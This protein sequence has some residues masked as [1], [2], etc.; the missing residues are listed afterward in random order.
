M[1]EPTGLSLLQ[2]HGGYVGRR[3]RWS[4]IRATRCSARRR[5]NT[6]NNMMKLSNHLQE[7]GDDFE[8]RHTYMGMSSKVTLSAIEGG[9]PHRC[10]RVPVF[11]TLYVDTRL[12]PGQSPILVRRELEEASCARLQPSHPD[13]AEPPSRHEHLHESMGFAVR[14]R[15]N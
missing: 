11:C 4:A 3:S 10:S 15:R 14:A 7:W 13:F 6:I 9:W 12:M 1:G 8:R 5:N 2:A